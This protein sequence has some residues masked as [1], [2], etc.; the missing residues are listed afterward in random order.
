VEDRELI[1]EF[2][3]ESSE[4]LT[5]L[6]TEIVDLEQRPN[7]P[8][9]LGSIFRTIHTIKGTCGFLAFSNL[10]SVTHIAENILSQ[11]RNGERS[12]T[13][14]LTSLV[15][16]T[17]DVIRREL[18]SIEAT[19]IESGEAYEDL[20]NRLTLTCNE[21]GMAPIAP[22]PPAVAPPLSSPPSRSAVECDSRRFGKGPLCQ[23]GLC[24]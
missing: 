21:V 18:A 12:L 13:P 8:A 10:E 6:E 11:L 3:I 19:S 5:R 24:R 23:G 14:Q 7:D 1:N 9:L 22:L 4:N 16:E 15:L 17:M 20:R 2:L